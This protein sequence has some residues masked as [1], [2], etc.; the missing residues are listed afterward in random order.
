MRTKH[1]ARLLT[2]PGFA[3]AAFTYCLDY[4]GYIRLPHQIGDTGYVYFNPATITS[5]FLLLTSG[6]AFEWA[7]EEDR[8]VGL[9]QA[10]RWGIF[11]MYALNI[12]YVG[13]KTAREAVHMVAGMLLTAPLLFITL[14]GI[15]LLVLSVPALIFAFAFEGSEVKRLTVY[16]FYIP[17]IGLLLLSISR[18]VDGLENLFPETE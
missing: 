10:K 7:N 13:R 16:F 18:A 8:R 6:N 11:C 17:Y 12:S 4:F 9:D 1:L 15:P 14:F 3:L 5:F 2:H